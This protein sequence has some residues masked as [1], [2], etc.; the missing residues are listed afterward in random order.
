MARSNVVPLRPNGPSPSPS[1]DDY[2]PFG[3]AGAAAALAPSP[4]APQTSPLPVSSPIMPAASPDPFAPSGPMPTAAPYSLAPGPPP[5]PNPLM[6]SSPSFGD[7][8]LS[9]PS[10]IPNPS[11]TTGPMA[12]APMPVAAPEK[13]GTPLWFW[14]IL[15]LFLGFGGGAAYFVFARVQQPQPVVIQMPAQQPAPA[16][17]PTDSAATIEVPSAEPVAA[18]EEK[19]GTPKKPGTKKSSAPT[20]GP[21]PKQGLDLGGLGGGVGG[22]NVGPGPGGGGGGGGGLDQN[23]VERVVSAHRAGVKR[24]CW[25]RGGADQKSSVNVTVTATVAPNGTVQSASSNGDDPVVGKCIENQV[26]TWTFPAPGSQ[27][28]INIPFKFVRQ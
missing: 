13:K 2:G 1:M 22:P 9:R 5:G 6:G 12:P 28:Q 16:A 8:S 4:V 17:T 14:P 23:G 25:E 11:F 3:G 18:N 7:G 21:E 24:T 10:F 19:P 26:R 15:V 27:T 20:T